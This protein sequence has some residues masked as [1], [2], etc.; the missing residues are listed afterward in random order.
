L[1]VLPDELDA[2]IGRFNVHEAQKRPREADHP[3]ARRHVPLPHLPEPEWISPAS[4]SATHS[5][6]DAIDRY[7]LRLVKANPHLRPRVGNPDELSSNHM[8]ETLAFLKHRVN[9]PE[10][11]VPEAVDGAVITALNEEAVIGAALGN[12]GGLNL[13][14]TYEAFAV[15][16]LGALRQGIIFA[17]H[18]KELGQQPGW[19]G[20]P[21]I[22]TSHTWENGKNEQSHQDTTIA[23]ALLGE[24]S[25]VSRVLFPPDAN[26]AIEA[27]RRIYAAHGQ[28][29]CLIVPKRPVPAMFDA[30]DAIKLCEAG[31][32]VV[33]GDPRLSD[34]QLVAIG[35]Y[36]F[37]EAL[38]AHASLEERG[39]RACLTVIVEPGRFR[40][41]RD[42]FEETFVASDA[43][44][45]RLFPAA[46]PRLIVTHTR[47]EPMIGH[48]RRID[49][50]AKR[51]RVLGY[52]NR[53]GTLDAA[54]MLF[55]NGCD[56]AHIVLTAL[57]LL[58][59][60]GSAE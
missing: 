29:G 53:G 10:A 15:K 2:A 25:D 30:Q 43:D 39:V 45:E 52:K 57:A 40:E 38:D 21:L 51:T 5:P 19:I 28:I 1:W 54:G 23:E 13:A 8:S 12:K 26:T 47:P 36:Q 11:G 31:A 3:L 17:R 14:V 24:M 6:M 48:L 50:G 60:N 42:S 58:G 59:Q 20:V 9:K 56:A 49:N 46:L 37:Q 41:P 22:A 18:Q 44:I 7:F 27:L 33:K 34:V 32:G 16:M 55:A 35:A 4:A